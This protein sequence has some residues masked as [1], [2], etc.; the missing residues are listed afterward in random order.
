M[1]S[2]EFYRGEEFLPSGNPQW[3]PRTC[4]CG[5]TGMRLLVGRLHQIFWRKACCQR[6]CLKR[7]QR[8]PNTQMR[9]GVLWFSSVNDFVQQW[10]FLDAIKGTLVESLSLCETQEGLREFRTSARPQ[11]AL[12]CV[13]KTQ[14]VDPG[15]AVPLTVK[16]KEKNKV[17]S[18]CVLT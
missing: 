14:T 3:P 8:L 11:L 5:T 16:Q 12:S 4:A 9:P 2:L 7:S 6:H 1:T 15:W 18:K 17:I 10:G 13:V